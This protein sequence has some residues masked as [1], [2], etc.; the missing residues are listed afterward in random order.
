MWEEKDIEGQN[1][2][3]ECLYDH[4]KTELV[5]RLVYRNGR[6]PSPIQD[7][8]AHTAFLVAWESFTRQGGPDG[9]IGGDSLLPYF[10][11]IV[12]NKFIDACKREMRNRIDPGAYQQMY[13]DGGPEPRLFAEGNAQRVKMTLEKVGENCREALLLKY[14]YKL[15]H[16]AIAMKK[17]IQPEAS[18]QMLW[19]CRKRFIELYE[20]R[21]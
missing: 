19:R 18:R 5:H 2:L 12:K 17:G 20:G 10:C 11:R 8:L 16:V 9:G 4:F 6:I 3:F 13:G 7:E 15:N 14:E 21:Q 1:R